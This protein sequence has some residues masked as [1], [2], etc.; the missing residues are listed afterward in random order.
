M[1][2]G[3]GIQRDLGR[4]SLIPHRLAEKGLGRI[5]VTPAAK[6]KLHGLAG[7]IDSSIQVHPLASNLHVRFIH[8]PRSSDW[9]SVALP[10]F[11]ELGRVM[12]DP[13]K[14]GGVGHRQAVLT[15]DGDQIARA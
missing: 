9:A 8:S 1:G 6:M 4:D 10:A 3:I 7:L 14:K 15:H 13:T 12:L 5:P 2:S 11:L